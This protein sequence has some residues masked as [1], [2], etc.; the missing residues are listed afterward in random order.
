MEQ[1]YGLRARRFYPD[2][3]GTLAENFNFD[4]IQKQLLTLGIVDK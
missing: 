3:I 4:G 2:E 1:N